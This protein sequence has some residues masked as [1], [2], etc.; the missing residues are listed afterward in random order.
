MTQMANKD[1]AELKTL[2]Y[3]VHT[4]KDPDDIGDL[5]GAIHGI[6][7]TGFIGKIYTMFPFPADPE[8]FKQDPEGFNTR[9]VVNEE[10]SKFS[11]QTELI[12]DFSKE[13]QIKLGPYLFD[14]PVFH[15]LIRYVWLGGYPRWKDEIRPQYVLDMKKN[16]MESHNLFFKG[17]FS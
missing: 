9:K 2:S 15:E 8:D 10:I 1:A 17:V 11:T 3:K 6:R 4:I 13:N 14:I 7:F 5:M 12:I 16:I